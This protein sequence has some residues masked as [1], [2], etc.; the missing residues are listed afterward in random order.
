MGKVVLSGGLDEK[1]MNTRWLS[2]FRAAMIVSFGG[3]VGCDYVMT[4]PPT[5]RNESG[6]TINLTVSHR[7]GVVFPRDSPVSEG[8]EIRL[9]RYPGS[10][11]K[12]ILTQDGKTIS[13]CELDDSQ[14]SD[15]VVTI[16]TNGDA[17]LEHAASQSSAVGD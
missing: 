2:V 12:V 15:V 11:K 16:D 1:F 14:T 5:L 10:A 7:D 8:G 6:T 13:E 17:H 4:F 3:M 9:G